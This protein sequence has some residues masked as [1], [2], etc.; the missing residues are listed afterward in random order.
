M[1]DL[2]ALTGA[3]VPDP[4]QAALDALHAAA[5]AHGTDWHDLLAD[6]RSTFPETAHAPLPPVDRPRRYAA[7]TTVWTRLEWRPEEGRQQKP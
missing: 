1:V 4:L 7:A 3:A 5:I 2:P 6:V